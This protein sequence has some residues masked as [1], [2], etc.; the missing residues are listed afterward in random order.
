[1]RSLDPDS[2]Y[3]TVLGRKMLTVFPNFN[4]VAV[5]KYDNSN[6]KGCDSLKDTEEMLLAV[7]ISEDPEFSGMD[8]IFDGIIPATILETW[9][10]R[11][12]E[13]DR[14]L[15]VAFMSTP[16]ET[17]LERIRERNNGKMLDDN[18]VNLVELK[19]RRIKSHQERH[20]DLFP[21]VKQVTINAETTIEHMLVSFLNRDWS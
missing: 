2:Y 13:R 5:G 8:L 18:L 1:M 19:Y 16:F 3:V 20:D 7:H 14:E 6:S 15:V 17:C 9:V 11:L 4:V 12:R 10:E 21:D